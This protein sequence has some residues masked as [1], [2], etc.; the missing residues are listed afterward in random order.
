VA[1]FDALAELSMINPSD[2]PIMAIDRNQLNKERIEI[3]KNKDLI[4]DTHLVELQLWDY[5]PKMFS[6]KNHV[7]VLSLYASLKDET[8]ERVEQ[9]LEEVLRGELWYTD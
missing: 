3:V 1:G 7:D 9:A 6:N 8:D 5:D 2:H 4:K